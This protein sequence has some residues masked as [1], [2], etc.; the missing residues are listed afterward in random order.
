MTRKTF[1]LIVFLLPSAVVLIFII[2][3]LFKSEARTYAEF[4]K[5]SFEAKD[6]ETLVNNLAR[7]FYE[8]NQV[9]P[10][11]VKRYL[12]SFFENYGFP[13]VYLR[14]RKIRK[15]APGEY[16]LS[17]VIRVLAVP[18]KG[19]VAGLYGDRRVIVFGDGLRGRNVILHISKT[20]EGFTVHN[21]DT[22]KNLGEEIK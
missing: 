1:N 12:T 8:N 13:E 16:T 22:G 6:V 17:L 21:F 2:S 18:Q 4:L 7:E 11:D 10:E 9:G 3:L 5:N 15:T 14:Y 19:T 20:G